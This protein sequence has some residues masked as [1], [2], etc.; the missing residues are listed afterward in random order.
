M[1]TTKTLAKTLLETLEIGTCLYLER[2]ETEADR[3]E[4][5]PTDDLMVQ[6][7]G[8]GGHYLVAGDEQTAVVFPCSPDDMAKCERNL[9][10]ADWC[11]SYSEAYY[12]DLTN[13]TVALDYD[14]LDVELGV[15]NWDSDSAAVFVFTRARNTA[16]DV[17]L[18]VVKAAAK[19]AATD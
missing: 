2:S 8:V 5:K 1:E 15:E 3:D 11:G 6:I 18:A 4:A 14:T 9:N 12:V 16:W 10:A 17:I 7:A 13:S 19:A